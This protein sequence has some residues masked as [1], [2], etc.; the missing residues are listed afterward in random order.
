MAKQIG[1]KWVNIDGQ[2]VECKVYATR[3]VPGCKTF[4]QNMKVKGKSCARIRNSR[5]T[6]IRTRNA[7]E[8]GDYLDGTLADT[9]GFVDP[10]R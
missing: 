10:N 2:L 7:Q 4:D 5:K 6:E 3:Q 9:L 1:T 8:K